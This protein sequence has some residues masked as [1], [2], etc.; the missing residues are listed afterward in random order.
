MLML[1]RWFWM[2]VFVLRSSF[3]WVQNAKRLSLQWY[4]VSGIWRSIDHLNSIQV[5]SICDLCAFAF[6][7]CVNIGS[8]CEVTTTTKTHISLLLQN[9]SFNI[10]SN[11]SLSLWNQY[12]EWDSSHQ[13]YI[14]EKT[15]NHFKKIEQTWH[16]Q[17]FV[18][19][20]TFVNHFFKSKYCEIF[21]FQRKHSIYFQIRIASS[22]LVLVCI[23]FF[24]DQCR[25]QTHGGKCK[26]I[27]SVFVAMFGTGI[28]VW[29]WR[30]WETNS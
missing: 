15:Q 16:G 12:S 9:R 1:R 10:N 30:K 17:R 2:R 14:E 21:Y 20:R 19:K 3:K 26:Q 27:F 29:I 13:I 23:W 8:A 24:G 25:N 22:Y 4:L 5:E 6:A 28:F 11:L 18:V 7:L